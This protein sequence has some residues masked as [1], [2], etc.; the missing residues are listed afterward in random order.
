MDSKYEQMKAE[1]EE[2]FNSVC[3]P[4][5]AKY[6]DERRKIRENCITIITILVIVNLIFH[7]TFNNTEAGRSLVVAPTL[8][9]SIISLFFIY[10]YRTNFLKKIKKVVMPSLSKCLGDLSWR[11]NGSIQANLIRSSGLVDTFTDTTVDDTFKG[12]IN[13]IPIEIGEVKLE[14]V[15]MTYKNR[16]AKMNSTE[17]FS[18]IIITIK[19]NKPFKG[20]TIIKP[21]SLTHTPPFE[22]LRHTT[23]EDVVFEKK[24]DV[25]TDDEIEARYLITTSFMERLVNVKTAFKAKTTSCA[26]YK[27]KIIIALK[28][29]DDLFE[30]RSIQEPIDRV[31][32]YYDMFNEIYS[33]TNLVEHFKLDQKIGL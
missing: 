9:F 1:F 12:K 29:Y 33:L 25:F 3:A 20:R 23:L 27:D 8:A 5:L 15:I 2:R 11:N 19:M 30:I 7:L 16:K 10:T 32:Q 4:E 28:S 6:E 24:Y 31:E 26:F 13:N 17:V 18:G 14:N 21:D 22:N